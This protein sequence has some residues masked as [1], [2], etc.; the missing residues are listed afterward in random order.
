M[1]ASLAA[2]PPPRAWRRTLA[3]SVAAMLVAGAAFAAYWLTQSAPT[4]TLVVQASIEGVEVFVD[5]HSRGRAPLNLEL[6]AGRHTIEMRGPGATKSFPVEIAAG[7]STTQNVKWPTPGRPTGSL[8]V[9]STPPGARVLLD[10][11]VR[12]MTP[13]VIEDVSAGSHTVTLE[14]EAGSVRR[15]VKVEVG[16]TAS[17]DASIFAGWLQVFA[18]FQVTVFTKGRP[19]G[20]DED[21]KLMLPSGTH[22]LEFVNE[23]LGVRLK[24]AVEITPGGTTPVSIEAPRGSVAVEAPDGTEV[25]IDGEL[26]GTT[27]LPPIG[28]TVGTREV[29]LRHPQL[30]QRRRVPQV[31]ASEPTRVTFTTP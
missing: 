10:G 20:S 7:V 19:V 31:S 16:A 9:T 26:K 28:V 8:R 27:P 15:S 3:A 23:G 14:S 29:V 12:G 18:P 6:P 2:E 25:W 22:Q 4:G 11:E 13:V 1:P 24:R 30:G 17:V 5:G 21:G